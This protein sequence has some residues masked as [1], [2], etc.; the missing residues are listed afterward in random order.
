MSRLIVEMDTKCSGFPRC[1]FP[2]EKQPALR[3]LEGLHFGE[4][5]FFSTAG[6]F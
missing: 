6:L 4:F 3:R 5:N 2:D 1:G